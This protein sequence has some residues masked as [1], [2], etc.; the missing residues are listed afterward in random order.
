MLALFSPAKINLFL[1]VLG[2]RIDGY[3]ELATLMQAVDFGDTLFLEPAATDRF[4][5]TERGLRLDSNNLILRALH[6]FRAHTGSSQ[7]YAIHLEKNIPIQSGLGG[8]SSNAATMLWGLNQLHGSVVDDATLSMWGATLGADV[9]FFFSVGTAD[10][11]GKGEQVRDLP[12]LPSSLQTYHFYK[13]PTGLSTQLIFER[14]KLESCSQRDPDAL[15][16]SVYAEMPQFCN[17]LEGIATEL[18]PPMAKL[19]QRLEPHYAHLWMTGSGTG[20]I[21]LKPIRPLSKFAFERGLRIGRPLHAIRRLPQEWFTTH[22]T[23][24]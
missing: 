7:S 2:R 4:T 6:L 19:R 5:C 14:L 21:G 15:L 1:R 3:H 17:D 8:G 11:R 13:P 10:C 24:E 22:L 18:S 12:P 9:P 20:L 16:H 23:H